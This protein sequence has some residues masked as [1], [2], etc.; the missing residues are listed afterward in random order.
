VAEITAA[1][2]PAIFV[3]FPQ[4]ADDHQR[5]NAE[6]IAQAGAALLVPQAALTP[7]RLAQLLVELFGDPQRLKKMGERARTLSHHDAASRVAR[8]V[9]ELVGASENARE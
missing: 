9:A 7:E 6:A 1:G 8:M 4:A 5:R 3:P 2:K